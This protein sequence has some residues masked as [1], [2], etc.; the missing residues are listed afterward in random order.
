MPIYVTFV[1]KS[2]AYIDSERTY[3]SR[4]QDKIANSLKQSIYV[5]Q[6]QTSERHQAPRTDNFLIS[7]GM[8]PSGRTV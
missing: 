6:N 4:L 2:P 3:H 5:F 8:V 7:I 1:A